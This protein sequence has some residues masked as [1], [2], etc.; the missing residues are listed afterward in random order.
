MGDFK[1][2]SKV[3]IEFSLK[4]AKIICDAL[5]NF[6]P[7]KEDEM[8]AFMLFSRIKSKVDK[9]IEKNEPW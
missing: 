2:G 9:Q 4:E 5:S 1:T 7:P 8:I 6:L 3:A